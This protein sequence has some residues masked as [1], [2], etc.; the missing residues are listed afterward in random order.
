MSKIVDCI[1]VYVNIDIY[2]IYYDCLSILHLCGTHT[3]RIYIAA[4]FF[5]C[6]RFLTLPSFWERFSSSGSA[7][8]HIHCLYDVLDA[9]FA[10]PMRCINAPL[11]MTVLHVVP[12]Y[13]CLVGRV[14]QGT[15]RHWKVKDKGRMILIQDV[16]K[17]FRRVLNTINT[18]LGTYSIHSLSIQNYPLL[19]VVYSIAVWGAIPW[20]LQLVPPRGSELF[21]FAALALDI[22]K[23]PMVL[24]F[25][26]SCSQLTLSAIGGHL[27]GK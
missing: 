20:L 15:L 23:T 8:V 17:N 6:T 4:C 10:P 16:L 7:L 14:E 3:I 27:T 12:V 9:I 18:A 19:G 26:K 21:F 13:R 11:L 2:R 1:C 22:R 24:K 25:R 5:F